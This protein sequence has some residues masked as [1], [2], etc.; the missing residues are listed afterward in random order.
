MLPG[1][2]A[3]NQGVATRCCVQLCAVLRELKYA[4]ICVCLCVTQYLSVDRNVSVSCLTQWPRKRSFDKQVTAFTYSK[5]SKLTRV[6]QVA[7]KIKK[8][9]ISKH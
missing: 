5:V 8:N 3:V 7:R 6:S 1:H 2:S 4:D 9:V